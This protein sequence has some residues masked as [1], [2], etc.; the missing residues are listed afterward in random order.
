MPSSCGYHLASDARDV[1]EAAS[2]RL[3]VRLEGCRAR[4]PH[5]VEKDAPGVD[6]FLRVRVACRENDAMRPA[7]RAI[8]EGARERANRHVVGP[9]GSAEVAGAPI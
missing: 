2:L 7:G 6:Q 1:K 3:W 9:D 8:D 4:L 5:I